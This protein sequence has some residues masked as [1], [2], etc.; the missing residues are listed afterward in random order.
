MNQL[1]NLR[2]Q[3]APSSMHKPSPPS[4]EPAVTIASNDQ[5]ATYWI[6]AELCRLGGMPCRHDSRRYGFA[7]QALRDA[8]LI[9]VGFRHGWNSVAS[10]DV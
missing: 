4:N 7:T 9:V 5:V 2:T 1:V 10:A 3:T 6:A 8:A